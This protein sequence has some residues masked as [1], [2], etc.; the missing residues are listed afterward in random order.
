[1]NGG[2]IKSMRVF[3]YLLLIFLVS[4]TI[5]YLQ[6]ID[7]RIDKFLYYYPCDEPIFY[8]IDTVDSRFGLTR[9][10]V[11]NVS[12]D[13]SEI[14]NR[15]YDKKL[16]FYDSKGDLS[17]NLIFD[18]R[19]ALVNQYKTLESGLEKKKSELDPKIAEYKNQVSSF[20]DRSKKLYEQVVYWNSQGGAPQEEFDKIVAEQ[21]ALQEEAS[22][23]NEMS[24]SLNQST[25]LFNASVYE[26]NRTVNSLNASLSERPEEGVYKESENRIEVYFNNNRSELTRT[27]AHEMGH[28]RGMGHAKDPDAI[29]YSKTSNLLTPTAEDRLMLDKA[30]EKQNKFVLL[31]E[32]FIAWLNEF[33]N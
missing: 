1:M 25:D 6:K 9:A 32:K 33:Q 5:F 12:Q 26:L 30:C 16:F 11:Q 4:L 24:K 28:A 3:R 29:M 18:T 13:A 22:K 27:I 8:R 10:Q 14:W 20:N 31:R 19:Q 7:F 23:L 21:K 17:I 2:L 15:I